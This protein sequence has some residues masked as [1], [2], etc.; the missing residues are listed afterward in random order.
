MFRTTIPVFF[1]A[2]VLV[3][4]V[5]CHGDVI[6]RLEVTSEVGHRYAVTHVTAAV[7]N[8]KP[9]PS[10]LKFKMLL[11]WGAYVSTLTI[12]SN[13][14]NYTTIV[15]ERRPHERRRPDPNTSSD[16]EKKSVTKKI[17]TTQTF[18]ASASVGANESAVFYLKYEE[19][20][21]RVKGKYTHRLYLRPASKISLL[22]V[23]VRISEMENITEFEAEIPNTYNDE[24]GGLS[25]SNGVHQERLSPSEILLTYRDDNITTRTKDTHS[26]DGDNEENDNDSKDE[27]KLDSEEDKEGV[28]S[29]SYDVDRQAD[30]GE[31]QIL[32]G[33]FVHYFCPEG[34][35]KLPTHTVFVLDI[36]GSMYDFGKLDQLKLAME[37]ILHSMKP[38]DSFEVLVFSTRV[39]SLGVF[40]ANPKDVERGVTKIKRLHAMGGTNFNE[41]LLKAIL[42]MNNFNETTAAKQVVF[43]TDGKPNLGETK[44]DLLRR[45][46]REANIHNYPIFSLAFGGDADMRLLRQVSTDNRGF[47]RKIDAHAQPADQ[48]KNFYEEIAT[49]LITDVDVMYLDDEVEPNTVVRQGTSTYYSGD[50]VVLAGQLAEGATQVR[51]IITGQG[52]SGPMQFRVS[53]VSQPAEEPERDNYV[54]RLWAYL[55]VQDLLSMQE[56]VED[57]NLRAEMRARALD[58]AVRFQFLTKLTSLDIVPDADGHPSGYKS[59]ALHQKSNSVTIRLPN[60]D[61]DLTLL[62]AEEFAKTLPA[63]LHTRVD[64]QSRRRFSFGDNDP[65]FVVQ[66]PGVHLPLCFDL[67][68]RNKDVFSLVRDHRSGIIVNG[69]VTSSADHPELTYFTKIFMSF[70]EVNFTVTPNSIVVDC[71]DDAGNPKVSTASSSLWPFKRRPRKR[72]VPRLKSLRRRRKVRRQLSKHI[73]GGRRR[74]AAKSESRGRRKRRKRRLSR[75][76][77]SSNKKLRTSA[78]SSPSRVGSHR[79][80]RKRDVLHPHKGRYPFYTSAEREGGHPHAHRYPPRSHRKLTRHSYSSI[81]SRSYTQTLQMHNSETPSLYISETSSPSSETPSSN[82]KTSSLSSEIPFS[83]SETLSSTSEIPSSNSE[84]PFSISGTP[85]STS[86][87]LSSPETVNHTSTH[88]TIPSFADSDSPT[89]SL[90]NI[91][92]TDLLNHSNNSPLRPQ[93]AKNEVSREEGEVT[94]EDEITGGN[95]VTGGDEVSGEDTFGSQEKGLRSKCSDSFG[96]NKA[97]G[98]SYGQVV[99]GLRNHRKL[100]ILMGDVAAHFVVTLSKNKHGQQFLGFY[101]EEQTI[102]SPNTT[103]VIGQFAFKTVGTLDRNMTSQNTTRVKLAVIQ[104]ATHKKYRVSQINA[105]VS[106]RRSLL[107][108]THVTCLFIRNQGRGLLAGEPEDYL[109]PCLTC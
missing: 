75:R 24:N 81:G 61:Q 39:T 76:K 103:G 95:E 26:E 3:V 52:R 79:P 63:P 62:S 67:H 13:G 45:N 10:D 66:V 1:A 50:E 31:I 65:H 107:H 43:L 2:V 84:T 87:T 53:R 57:S 14:K 6:S 74:H 5:K 28:L 89:I 21:Q 51:P 86:E 64:T 32:G 22:D 91:P 94:G 49:P 88:S 19:L 78:S 60:M 27:N 71:L 44:S 100:E 92:R 8:S 41:A 68:G 72:R 99:V 80:R 11:P 47:T 33:F 48:L 7:T 90:I 97:S 58:I 77:H 93:R 70:G 105:F 23:K 73:P 9:R 85:S 108:K 82:S 83:N 106:S 15:R 36:S 102:L 96:W 35:P 16:S 37:S 104:P 34:L 18:R 69:E 38:E 42:E 12:E 20:L 46:V 54:E 17:K 29:I 98:G 56:V 40:T 4:Q 55:T 25:G 30:G 101:V 59:A 109:R